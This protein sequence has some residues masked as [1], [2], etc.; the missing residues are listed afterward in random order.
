MEREYTP[1]HKL[2]A[3]S[4]VQQAKLVKAG[5]AAKPQAAALIHLLLHTDLRIS[6]CH[7]LN[8]ENLDLTEGRIQLVDAKGQPLRQLSINAETCNKLSIWLEARAKRFADRKI[9]KALFFKSSGQT[10][11]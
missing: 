10:H 6:E 7:A 8:L 1:H 5:E 4:S 3:L 9:D 2:K 11:V